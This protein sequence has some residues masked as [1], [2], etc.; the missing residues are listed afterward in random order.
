MRTKT[1]KGS[2]W[3]SQSVAGFSQGTRGSYDEHI[4]VFRRAKKMRQLSAV[5]GREMVLWFQSQ[6]ESYWH[7]LTFMHM[8]RVELTILELLGEVFLSKLKF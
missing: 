6:C 4:Q 2:R 3:L 1:T 8:V 5:T 7:A